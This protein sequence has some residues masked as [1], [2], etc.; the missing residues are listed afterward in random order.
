ML[1]SLFGIEISSD[2]AESM[3]AN[4]ADYHAAYWS[5]YTELVEGHAKHDGASIDSYMERAMR[6]DAAAA[7]YV[8]SWHFMFSP[9]GDSYF[10]DGDRLLRAVTSNPQYRFFLG[11]FIIQ[12]PQKDLHAGLVGTPFAELYFNHCA[13]Y[14]LN[15]PKGDHSGYAEIT[16][17]YARADRGRP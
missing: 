2:D 6:G 4:A 9:Y 5:S 16:T 15:N 11:K 17:D 8:L 12:V 7:W 3:Q 14:C 1:K 13:F 10:I